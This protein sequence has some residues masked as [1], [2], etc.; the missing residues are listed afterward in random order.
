MY[1]VRKDENMD[2]NKKTNKMRG[3]NQVIKQIEKAN[4]D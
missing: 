1:K 4:K 2:I 3:F